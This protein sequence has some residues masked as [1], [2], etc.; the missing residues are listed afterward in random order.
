MPTLY[1]S[2]EE[3]PEQVRLRAERLE[4]DTAGVPV[5]AET[6][7]ERVIEFIRG[8]SEKARQKGAYLIFTVNPDATAKSSVS[9]IELLADYVVEMKSDGGEFV[10]VK[11]TPNGSP[12]MDW[13][14][15]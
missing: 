12:D 2:G 15:A 7:L 14:P 6:A 10:R 3:S 1:A 5:L 11:K 4:E 9:S 13:R 8:S